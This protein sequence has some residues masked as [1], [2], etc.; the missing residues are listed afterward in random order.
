MEPRPMP[1]RVLEDTA[2]P[3]TA[4]TREPAPA[5]SGTVALSRSTL[6]AAGAAAL[7]AIAA[8][9]LAIGGGSAGTVSVVGAVPLD[10]DRPGAASGPA[11]TDASGHDG[12][13]VVEIVGAVGHPG[14][15]RMAKN[16]RVGDLLTAAG[17]YGPRV[18][19][20][21][22]ARELNLAAPL[23]DGDQVRVP[24]RDDLAAA[25]AAPAPGAGTASGAGSGAG[26]SGPDRP[27]PRDR[28][29]ARH[30]ARRRTGDRGQDPRLTRRAALRRGGRPKDQEAGWRE[31]VRGPQGPRDGALRWVA[32]VGWPSGRS[33]RRSRP[34][35]SRRT[36]WARRSR[37]CW[38]RSC[39]SARHGRG[40]ASGACCRPC[41]APASSPSGWRSFRPAHHRSIDPRRRRPVGARR[42]GDRFAE[43]WD[44]TATL[45]TPAGAESAF[46][47]AA[48]LPRYPIVTRATVS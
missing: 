32:A 8:L 39:S 11:A 5:G 48:T 36:I 17:G 2:G 43:G 22:A 31:D 18:D 37:W 45:A 24:S 25:S 38:H 46:R 27:E 15:F 30:A 44:Q 4:P 35:R 7:L 16:A 9:G 40:W 47:V 3:E 28:R 14:V 19:A 41:S 12:I 13:V 33:Q 23:H 26:S 10:S 29:R 6:L 42:R 34:A 21:R 1:W 20:G